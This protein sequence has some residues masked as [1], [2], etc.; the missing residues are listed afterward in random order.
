MVGGAYGTSKFA[1]DGTD[2]FEYSVSGNTWDSLPS[3]SSGISHFGLVL[4]TA[5]S[6]APSAGGLVIVGGSHNNRALVY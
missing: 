4:A 1:K 2:V 6:T 5:P 3:L